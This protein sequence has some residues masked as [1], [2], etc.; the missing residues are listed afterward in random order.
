RLGL[1]PKTDDERNKHLSGTPSYID[2]GG[3]YA[4]RWEDCQGSPHFEQRPVLSSATRLLNL[5]VKTADGTQW[6][7]AVIQIARGTGKDSGDASATTAF[8]EI[9]VDGKNPLGL[10][11]I[12]GDIY[13]QWV[14]GAEGSTESAG[15]AWR[16]RHD[17]VSMMRSE[18]HTS[19]L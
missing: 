4:Y 14:F 11:R 2:F 12:E 10:D 18:E 6:Y 19:E 5:P 15:V 13:V 7:L 8:Y 16:G 3:T 17:P 1:Y 9:L